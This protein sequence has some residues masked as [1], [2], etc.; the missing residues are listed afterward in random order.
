[1]FTDETVNALNEELNED[2]IRYRAGPR[3]SQLAYLPGWYV[4]E[5]LNAIFGYD[6]W[7]TDLVDLQQVEGG[8]LARLRL[9]VNDVVREDVGF[10]SD[11]DSTESAIKSAVTDALKR[12]ARTFGDQFGNGLYASS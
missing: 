3:G 9:T 6:S 1:M 5:S 10:G 8:W 12:A 4:I 11:E 2:A 7:R